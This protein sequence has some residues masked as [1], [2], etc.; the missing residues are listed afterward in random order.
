[1]LLC[2]TA[3]DVYGVSEIVRVRIDSGNRSEQTGDFSASGE[4][5]NLTLKEYL[6]R[7]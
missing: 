3:Q 7:F 4:W 1:M 5:L 2:W 6:D